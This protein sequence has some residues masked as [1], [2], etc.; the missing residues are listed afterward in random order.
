MR[1][2]K[3][4]TARRAR[5]TPSLRTAAARAGTGVFMLLAG[6]NAFTDAAT[7]LAYDLEGAASDLPFREGAHFALIHRTPSARGQCEGPYRVQFDK[8]G[9]IV[10]WCKNDRGETV[11]SHSTSYHSRF[12]DTA[13]TIILDKPAGAPLTIDL[14][15]RQGHAVIV[16]AY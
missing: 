12:V 8:V 10:I 7:R 9:L 2:G 1:S 6:C 3:T 4:G 16:D 11:S 13:R 5:M 15:R 14:E